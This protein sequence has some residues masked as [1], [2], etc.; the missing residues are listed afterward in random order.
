MADFLGSEITR[1]AETGVMLDVLEDLQRTL[2]MDASQA[3]EGAVERQLLQEMRQRSERMPSLIQDAWDLD[4]DRQA[5]DSLSKSVRPLLQ[6]KSHLDRVFRKAKPL[7]VTQLFCAITH[8]VEDMEEEWLA[9]DQVLCDAFDREWAAIEQ[10]VSKV[11]EL[12]LDQPRL[13]YRRAL[14]QAQRLAEAS[15]TMQIS[16]GVQ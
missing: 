16:V 4:N 9:D 7:L 15:G 11:A 12:L 10:T 5:L 14:D 8:D 13:D 1:E 2:Q 6:I 3:F